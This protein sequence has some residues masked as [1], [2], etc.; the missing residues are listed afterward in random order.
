LTIFGNLPISSSN[1]FC[2]GGETGRRT[3]LK[4]QRG[5]LHAGSIPAPGTNEI[6]GSAVSVNPFFGA[7]IMDCARNYAHLRFLEQLIIF[8]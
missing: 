3:G 6:K 4:I 1:I 7:E 2:R 8:F 5:L